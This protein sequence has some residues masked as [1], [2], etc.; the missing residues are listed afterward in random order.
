MGAVS[1]RARALLLL[2]KGKGERLSPPPYRRALSVCVLCRSP[3]SC[4]C[5]QCECLGQKSMLPNFQNPLGLTHFQDN[6]PPTCKLYSSSNFL[7]TPDSQWV[8]LL[9]AEPHH[10][11]YPAPVQT[12]LI[13]HCIW[14]QIIYLILDR[15]K[16]KKPSSSNSWISWLTKINI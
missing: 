10:H 16:N 14:L 15:T 9:A 3:V 11:Y 1:V 13:Q 4:F 8:L 5:A 7:F 12:Q 2:W 6:L